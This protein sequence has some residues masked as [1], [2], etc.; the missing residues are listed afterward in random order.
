MI[1]PIGTDVSKW[2]DDNETNVV[3]NFKSMKAGGALWSIIKAG[4]NDW[5]DPDFYMNWENSFGVLPR[6]AYW[7]FDNRAEPK[8]QARK[9]SSIMKV[10]GDLGEMELW[11]DLEDSVYKTYDGWRN[12]YKFL[13]ELENTLPGK[14]IGIYTGYYY[15]R[16]RTIPSLISRAEL[17]WFKKYPLWI[18]HYGV[19]Y[20]SIPQ[21]WNTWNFWQFTD[22]GNGTLYGVESL[23]IDLNYFNGSAV[24][25]QKRYNLVTIPN[26]Q[27]LAIV[28]KTDSGDYQFKEN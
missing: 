18:A 8:A 23:N 21:P 2:Q 16:E 11:A 9:F 12:W 4:Q 1:Y 22:N 24:E 19:P 25:F 6:G 5:V 10:A 26:K 15:W 17:E 13:S 20:P 27:T 7:Y 14:A 3:V 28:L